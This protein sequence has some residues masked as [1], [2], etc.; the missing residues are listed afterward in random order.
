MPSPLAHFAINADDVA[1]AQGFYEAVFG[2]KFNAWGPP[3]SS[4][5]ILGVPR[6]ILLAP[7]SSAATLFPA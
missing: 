2:W 7:C 4:R 3:D 6:L 1:R 5:L